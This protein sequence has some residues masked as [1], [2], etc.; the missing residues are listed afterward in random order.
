MI[1]AITIENFCSGLGTSAFTAFMMRIVDKRYTAAQYA[2]LTS[3]MALTRTM[4]QAPSGF[5]QK[6]YG[7][8]AYFLISIIISIPGLLL[9]LRYDKWQLDHV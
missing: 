5:V 8:E 3:F 2:L 1:S 6:A 9:L 7:W 4:V